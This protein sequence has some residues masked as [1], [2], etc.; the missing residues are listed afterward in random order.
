M[1]MEDVKIIVEFDDNGMREEVE[2][3]PHDI[4]FCLGRIVANVSK[5]SGASIEELCRMIGIS[6]LVNSMD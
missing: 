1:K 2:G 3:K 4:M 5:S 6:C